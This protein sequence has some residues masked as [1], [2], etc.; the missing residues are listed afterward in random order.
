M[1]LSD[2]HER[3]DFL[4]AG[5]TTDMETPALSTLMTGDVSSGVNWLTC[6]TLVAACLIGAAVAWL[7]KRRNG[8]THGGSPPDGAAVR[9]SKRSEDTA[10]TFDSNVP[11][12]ISKD[13]MEITLERS[14]RSESWGFVWHV[15]A[16]EAQRFLI[17][18]LEAKSPAG[19]LKDRQAQ[20]LRPL[21]RG[22]ELVSVNGVCHFQSMR[23][24]LARAEK[25]RLQ[26][27]KADLVL[28]LEC[29]SCDC[30]SPTAATTKPGPVVAAQDSTRSPSSQP[31]QPSQTQ[32]ND[33][34]PADL[35][36]TS[37]QGE[38]AEVA[39]V[40]GTQCSTAF[41]AVEHSLPALPFPSDSLRHV[42]D[43]IPDS[44]TQPAPAMVRGRD[45]AMKRADLP[46]WC[47]EK[48]KSRRHASTGA[49]EE[50]RFSS[51]SSG[52]GSEQVSGESKCP[53]TDWEYM[54]D[55]RPGSLLHTEL[56]TREP[57]AQSLHS[58]P[59][60][61]TVGL[62]GD[63]HAGSNVVIVAGSQAMALQTGALSTVVG[64]GLFQALPQ[65]PQLP[66]L[67]L[68]Q[69]PLLPQAH[70]LSQAPAEAS[71]LADYV[72]GFP[73]RTARSGQVA[74]P[75]PTSSTS[76]S[77]ALEVSKLPHASHG[78]HESHEPKRLPDL[79]VAQTEVAETT[80]ASRSGSA[81]PRS[82]FLVPEQPGPQKESG[83]KRTYRSG[84]R[85]RAKRTRAAQRA[86]VGVLTGQA[87]QSGEGE[88]GEAGEAGEP[89]SRPRAGSAPAALRSL[90]LR[91]SSEKGYYKPR[92]RAGKKVRQR[93]EHAIARRK[94]Q[95]LMAEAAEN[96]RMVSDDEPE[97]NEAPVE[98]RPV[99]K[100]VP[101][102]H[103]KPSH[104]CQK[105]ADSPTSVSTCTTAAATMAHGRHT[106]QRPQR[107]AS[108]TRAPNA[109]PELPGASEIVGQR[110]LLTG[111]VHAPHFNGHWG[112][113][114][115]F[116]TDQQRYIVRVFLGEPGT[117]PTVVTCLHGRICCP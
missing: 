81:P 5:Y 82:C 84:K 36:P 72:Q 117:P 20:G 93:M 105:R 86:Q 74:M 113:V 33:S 94:E 89:P 10:Q 65:L 38:V 3:I 106:A 35:S 39:E 12:D 18:G 59:R 62:H 53:S 63:F 7:A 22:D 41:C 9:R 60:A 112:Y 17:A 42:P 69:I 23:R 48:R 70:I 52:S 55:N 32:P 8:T 85:I 91:D 15:Q 61:G 64:G 16:F 54:M 103:A 51:N 24:H 83:K 114:D 92:R 98:L 96:C 101:V 44:I 50:G 115:G 77:Q 57:Q 14:Q 73:T 34:Q 80:A 28:P 37:P 88:A 109:G 95:A 100:P 26:F 56:A 2:W 99:A 90:E 102:P 19:Q 111:L 11:E 116:D 78:S 110:V 4:K 6:W 45:T 21:R 87:A 97:P 79:P 1:G 66:Q 40:A 31:S 29:D 49:E 104:A 75:Q 13:Y 67:P 25:V 71:G 76:L 46:N 107:R 43:N 108:R 68:P 27:L 47:K 30:D 58:M